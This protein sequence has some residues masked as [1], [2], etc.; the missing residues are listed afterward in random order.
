MTLGVYRRHDRYR[1]ENVAGPQDLSNLRWTVDTPDDYAFVAA[2]YDALYPG[3]PQ[4]DLDDV[5]AWLKQ[6]P[7]RSRTVTDSA[8]NAALQGLDTGAMQ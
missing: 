8:R 4:F 1:V 5:L 7:E 3:N 6:H 2:V